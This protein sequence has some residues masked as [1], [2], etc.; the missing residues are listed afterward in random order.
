MRGG[1]T[2]VEPSLDRL[3]EVDAAKL[4]EQLRQRM[5]TGLVVG[6]QRGEG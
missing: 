3:T 6:R 4:I 1:V 5:S 2:P